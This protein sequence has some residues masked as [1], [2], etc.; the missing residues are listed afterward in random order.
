MRVTRRARNFETCSIYS[1]ALE[2]ASTAPFSQDRLPSPIFDVKKSLK[3]PDA[4]TE[5]AARV[6]RCRG[7][8]GQNTEID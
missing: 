3:F 7:L 4:K 1:R 2:A 6:E 8:S 5:T